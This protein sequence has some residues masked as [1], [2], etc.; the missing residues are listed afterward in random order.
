M[1]FTITALLGLQ[2]VNLAILIM[3]ACRMDPPRG[4]E[5]END[6]TR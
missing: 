4:E 1:I 3:M 5:E 6:H 2:V